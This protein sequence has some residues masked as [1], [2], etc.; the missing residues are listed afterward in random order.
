MKMNNRENKR[1]TLRGMLED[2]STKLEN[3]VTLEW[4]AVRLAGD[5]EAQFEKDDAA[6]NT[7]KELAALIY[8]IKEATESVQELIYY[9]LSTQATL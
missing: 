8:A 5:I 6:G 4:L 2:G 3:I 9:S 1:E 7:V